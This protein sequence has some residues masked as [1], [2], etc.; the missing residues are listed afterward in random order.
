LD[1]E[2]N[3]KL[4]QSCFHDVLLIFFV[5]FVEIKKYYLQMHSTRTFIDFYIS[6]WPIK[7][8]KKKFYSA[9]TLFRKL[10]RG[11]QNNDCN[12]KLS[13]TT[14]D[15]LFPCFVHAGIDHLQASLLFDSVRNSKTRNTTKCSIM[16][17]LKI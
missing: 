2:F 8:S 9:Q 17:S 1:E 14:S 4:K 12:I 7:P 10:L 5:L 16:L 6:K 11:E 15:S 3:E 13:M